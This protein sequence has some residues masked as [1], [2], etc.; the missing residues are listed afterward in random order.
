MSGIVKENNLFLRKNA[1]FLLIYGLLALFIVI[2]GMMDSQFLS[3]RNL[4]NLFITSLPFLIGTY[5][6]TI[7]ILSGGVDLS[8]GSMISLVTTICATRMIHDAGW[9]FL[10][11]VVLALIVG[12]AVG[13]LNGLLITCFRL[14]PLIV[15]LSTSLILNGFALF[16]LEKPGGRVHTGFA[17]MMNGT[18]FSLVL[19]LLCTVLLWLLLNY[20]RFG[21]AVYAVGGNENSAYTAGI[22]PGRTKTM[23]FG[24]V[25]ILAAVAGI[26]MACQMYSGDPT[27]GAPLTLR[28]MTASVIGGTSFSGGKGRIECVIA[29]VFILSIINNILN[30]MGISAFYQYVAQGI[31]LIF[32]IAVTSRQPKGR[33][34]V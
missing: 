30:L 23:A 17:K 21:R 29:G 5:A 18:L 27:A 20:T 22:H 4:T 14:Q 10:P 2:A 13:V 1:D 19:F 24:L 7:A 32:A 34:T 28:T 6:Q 12:G 31:I 8:I 16:V 33:V 11:G 26:I 15:T 9:G 3:L 25:G